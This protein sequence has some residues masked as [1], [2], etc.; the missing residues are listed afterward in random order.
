[1]DPAW[2]TQNYRSIAWDLVFSA[3]QLVIFLLSQIG[4]GIWVQRSVRVPREMSTT[5]HMSN[6]ES[7]FRNKGGSVGLAYSSSQA[8]VETKDEAAAKS[9][10]QIAYDEASVNSVLWHRAW[11]VLRYG[12]RTPWQSPKLWALIFLNLVC[13][14]AGAYIIQ[15][16]L[17]VVASGINKE[18]PGIAGC[19]KSGC[20]KVPAPG[21]WN[22]VVKYMNEW[23]WLFVISMVFVITMTLLGDL[24]NSHMRKN[25][26]ST[27][28]D[29]LLQDNK[30]CFR[31]IVEAKLDNIDQRITNDLQNTIDGITCVLFGNVADYVAYPLFFTITRMTTA[32]AMAY[33]FLGDQGTPQ[34][35][36]QCVGV[37]LAFVFIAVCAYIFPINQISRI[38]YRSLQYEGNFRTTHTRA[39]LS[40]ESISALNGEYA[41]KDMADKQF[42]DIDRNNRKYYLWQ[43]VLLVLRLFVTLAYPAGAYVCLVLTRTTNSTT[44]NFF[45]KQFGDV[46]E[47]ALYLPVMFMRMAYSCGATHR[48]GELLEQ[49]ELL[50]TQPMSGANARFEDDPER[51]Q[52]SNVFA[53]P[54][55]R[56]SK[57]ADPK[58]KD[59]NYKELHTGQFGEEAGLVNGQLFMGVNLH[60]KKGESLVIIGPS[61]CGKSSLL[62]VIG[63]LWG[64]EKGTIVRPN[65]KGSGGLFFLPQKAY[66]FPGTLREQIVYPDQDLEDQG[67]P[68][69]GAKKTSPEAAAELKQVLEQVFLGHLFDR[70]GLDT[71]ADFPAILSLSEMQ[72][73]NFARVFYH[74]PAFCLADEATS[75]LDL[76]LESYLLSKCTAEGISLISVA[77]RPTVLPHHSHILSYDPKTH[78]WHQMATRDW[79][80]LPH[81]FPTDGLEKKGNSSTAHLQHEAVEKAP[82]GLGR[83]FWRRIRRAMRKIF[84][85]GCCDSGWQMAVVMLLVMTCYGGLQILIY[86]QYGTSLIIKKVITGQYRAAFKICFDVIGISVVMA[87]CQALSCFLGSLLACKMHKG[88]I[89][90]FHGNY[91]QPGVVYHTN[92]I[93]HLNGIDQ[94]MVQ[95]LGGFREALTWYFG[96]PFAYFNYHIGFFPLCVPMIMLTVYAFY[97]GWGL[98]IFMAVFMI[99]ALIA[100]VF[101]SIFTSKSVEVRQGRE[102]ELRRHIARIVQNVESITF[103]DGYAKERQSAE[104]L[105]HAFFISRLNYSYVAGFT[106]VPTITMYYWLQTG[107]YVMAAYIYH[108]N[109]SA[110]DSAEFFS[111]ISFNI[112]WAKTAFFIIQAVGNSGLVIGFSH[113]VMQV[114]EELDRA[115]PYV[116]ETQQQ[117]VRSSSVRFDKVSIATPTVDPKDSTTILTDFSATVPPDLCVEGLGKSSL[118]R[119]LHG[120]WRPTSGTV[121]RPTIG[122]DG[123]MFAPQQSYMTQGTLAAQ[124]VYPSLVRDEN[125]EESKLEAILEEVGLGAIVRRWGLNTNVPWETVLSGGE[126]QRLGFARI[127][128]HM[129][130][131]AVLDETTS[132]LDMATEARCMKALV[133][134]SMSLLSMA[135]RPSIKAYHQDH[136]DLSAVGAASSLGPVRITPMPSK[137]KVG[138]SI[139]KENDQAKFASSPHH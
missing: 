9:S 99:L 72:R 29:R 59:K 139:S 98:S 20:N 79:P 106:N 60:V 90:E 33:S 67:E 85:P 77:H 110:I 134:R 136:V 129:P 107:I 2:S 13:Q 34:V 95:D 80:G 58:S 130:K 41:E 37:V 86:K 32:F 44:A 15:A 113:R 4:G 70:Y 88:I 87:I 23:G 26:S 36:G 55:V 101:A 25:A 128:Y 117:I 10:S 111:G 14:V 27:I 119:V 93:Q 137:Q 19:L 30:L 131:F 96:N 61:G 24:I 78:S 74:K 56:T 91:F 48:V 18:Y 132:A 122:K 75:S 38:F 49:M 133:Q 35:K 68:G 21:D 102:G 135:A 120:L 97:R 121:Q 108:L 73:L 54:P 92:R 45:Q 46:F 11:R 126:A 47:Y 40:C 81:K 7:P 114:L 89:N 8:E 31:L 84:A 12:L 94:R 62:R 124:I 52:L 104:H 22:W 43:G 76:P 109:P 138:R 125:P 28:Q 127:L 50:E 6:I 3:P 64:I 103:F 42:R 112:I 105:L 82:E 17:Y 65:K 1:M 51:I 69:E 16:R 39:V 5:I 100:Q 123:I 66:V 83:V 71:H 116:V 118:L 53:N 63:G 57:K 115:V